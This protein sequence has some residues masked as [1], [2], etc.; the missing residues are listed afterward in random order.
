M[1]RSEW[2]F[3][4]TALPFQFIFPELLMALFGACSSASSSV[5]LRYVHLRYNIEFMSCL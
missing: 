1:T 4:H 3:T 5:H 2:G